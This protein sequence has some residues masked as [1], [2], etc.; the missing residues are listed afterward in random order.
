M[1]YLNGCYNSGKFLQRKR[2]YFGCAN[3]LNSDKVNC[4]FMDKNS[5]IAGTGDGIYCFRDGKFSRICKKITGPVS[6]IRAVNDK[7]AVLNGNNLWIVSGNKAVQAYSF[8]TELVDFAVNAKGTWCLTKDCIYCTADEFKNFLLRRYVEGGEAHCIAVSDADIYVA[9]DS[10]IS[11]VHGKRM[12]W[13]TILPRFSAL[14]DKRIN[15]LTF[16]ENGY[17]WIGFNDG[18]AIYDNGANRIV[19]DK[20]GAV[21]FASDAGLIILKNGNIKYLCADRWVPDNNINDVVV[22][23]DGNV[24][25][26]ATDKGISKITSYYTTLSEKA[27]KFEK[28][29]EKYHIRRGFTATRTIT[30]N[31]IDEGYISISD[32][33]GL[34]TACYVAAESFR[35]A[36]TKKKDALEKARR[37]MNALLFLTRITG[38]KGFT[39]RAVRY[40][41]EEGFG[42]GNKEWTLSPDGSCEWKGETSSD[43]M[44]G[45]FFGFSVYYDLC[46]NKKEKEEI[47]VALC[48]IM[49]HI[50]ENDYRLI[51]KDGLP[52]TW[53]CW[54]PALL[55]FDDRW[56]N[57][58]ELLAFLKICAHISDDEKYE[59]LYRKFVSVHR[60]PLNVMQHKVRD[61][62]ICHIDDN[63]AFLASLAYLRLEDNPSVRSLIL[64]G[65]EDHWRYERVEKQPLFCFIHAVF[66]GE[67]ED[68]MEGVQS[69][70]EIPED[71]M[72]YAMHNSKRKDLV[73]DDEQIEWFEE[74]QLKY[75]LAFDERNIHRPDGGV[76]DIDVPFRHGC[77]EPTVYLLPYWIA[78]YYGLI[79][80]K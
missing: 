58:L 67:D 68:L 18:V 17:L 49:D 1:N 6:G 45:H 10:N 41:G 62:H 19:F 27:D 71:L 12:E 46:A 13:K 28:I 66:T 63:L 15:S 39:A 5:L 55:N 57:S 74:P 22:S 33:D 3:G 37:G 4:V 9:T 42:N 64:C 77:Q 61:A 20:T 78:R 7:Y 23:D 70:R 8:E 24:I 51:D 36:A 44:T 25:Y 72:H 40:P 80:E 26:A 69:L 14:P 29:I 34:W 59:K 11:V 35:Y 79:G 47:R 75:P 54:D 60:Y 56:Y 30:G 76:F 53:A 50:I 52:T 31:T 73:Y 21:Y 32:N 38:I 16:D 2:E 43:E 65:M 48:N